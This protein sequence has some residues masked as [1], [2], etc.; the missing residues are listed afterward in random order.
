[1]RRLHLLA[2]L[3]AA[4]CYEPAVQDCT[5]TCSASDE[6]AGEQVCARGFCVA[7]G[8]VTCDGTGSS[9]QIVVL[10]VSIEGKGKVVITDIGTCTDD[11]A[12]N[13]RCRWSVALGARI[14]LAAI[15]SPDHD[16]E[17]WTA[18]CSGQDATCTLTATEPMSIGAKF[19]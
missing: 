15:A 6:C 11:D 10:R 1:M 18:G 16:F 14:Q 17:A 4:G 19:E 12:S 8:D 13:D 2:W 3:L 5:V 7:S 9:P